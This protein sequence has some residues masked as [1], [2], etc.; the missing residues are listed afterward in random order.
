VA[1]TTVA[2]GSEVEV[3]EDDYWAEYLRDAMFNAHMGTSTNSVIQT[4]EDLT[5]QAGDKINIPLVTKLTN[6]PTTGDNTLEGNEEALGNYNYQLTVD[7]LRHAVR[8]GKMEQQKTVIPLLNAG[9]EMLKLWSMDDLRDEIIGA[10]QCPVTDGTTKMADAT[11]AQKDAFAAANSDRI[12]AGAVVSNYNAD[13]STML[14][15]LDNTND[16][17]TPSLI[18]LAKRKARTA[19]PA[20]RP[21]KVK[22]GRE[23]F[24]LFV[25]SLQ[26]RDLKE[27]ATMTQANREA[28]P[29]GTDNPL[30]DDSDLLWDGVLVKEV[31][32]MP[33]IT[34]GG[35]AGIDVAVGAL[36]GAQAVALGWAQRTKTATESFDYGNQNG[37][38]ISEI[39]GEAK[40]F[41]KNSKQ[42]GVVSIYTA[43]VADS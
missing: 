1:N 24:V 27:H 41:F 25:G 12:I 26:F 2:S 42:H 19:S 8:V 3:W 10:L 7:Q 37:V 17:L 22:G 14:G 11:E 40:P 28:M 15:N 16:K 5:K 38:A 32:E 35:A 23:Y 20:I 13:H 9:R 39:R 36:C 21:I 31:P 34:G 30:F 43:A 6:A 18:S 33:V 4:F 29:R